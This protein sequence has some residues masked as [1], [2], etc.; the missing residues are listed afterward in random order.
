[1]RLV[2]RRPASEASDQIP[3]R[4]LESFRVRRRRHPEVDVAVD[5]VVRLLCRR[6]RR[7]KANARRHHPDDRRR[8][9]AA[10]HPQRLAD[11]VRV[12]VEFPLP[13]V[14]SDD[15]HRRGRKPGF[16]IQERPPEH[17]LHAE[18]A[19]V[20]ACDDHALERLTALFRDEKVERPAVRRDAFERAGL[21]LPFHPL[22]RRPAPDAGRGLP[23]GPDGLD[24]GELLRIFVGR[25]RQQDALDQAEHR[26]RRADA[27]RQRQYGK[28]GEARLL[29][30]HP[31]T[32]AKVLQHT[33]PL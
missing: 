9:L 2:E 26:S 4:L 30:Q 22:L 32:E 5:V 33:P 27:E 13:Q 1:M 29:A 21:L 10:A 19:K 20:V 11:D 14:V 7:Q 28:G 8:D 16:R 23:V 31:E 12:A 24:Q 6:R 15:D 3:G 17:R 25:R 18:H